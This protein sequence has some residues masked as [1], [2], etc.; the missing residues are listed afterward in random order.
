MTEAGNLG[1]ELVAAVNV[2]VRTAHVRTAER[3][4]FDALAGIRQLT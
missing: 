1:S 2:P 3:D 4:H